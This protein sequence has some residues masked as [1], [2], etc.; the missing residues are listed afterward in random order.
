MRKCSWSGNQRNR[1]QW[2]ASLKRQVLSLDLKDKETAQSRAVNSTASSQSS[3]KKAH[4]PKMVE[5]NT[6]SQS[7][8]GST[9]IFAFVKGEQGAKIGQLIYTYCTVD[10]KKNFKLE[11]QWMQDGCDM[12][13]FVVSVM[14][15]AQEFWAICSCANE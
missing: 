12:L 7:T 14:V 2:L 9:A 4:E 3:T 10:N 5:R 15:L 1:L 8:S 11:V 6:K 13:V